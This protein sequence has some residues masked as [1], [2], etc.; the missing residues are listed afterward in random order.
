MEPSIRLPC[1]GGAVGLIGLLW[2]LYTCKGT[3]LPR[4]R[5]GLYFAPLMLVLLVLI[6][7]KCQKTSGWIAMTSKVA[8]LLFLALAA[9][10]ATQAQADFLYLWRYDAGTKRAYRHFADEA[11]NQHRSLRVGYEWIFGPGLVFYRVMSGR[12]IFSASQCTMP[13]S[14]E[15]FDDYYLGGDTAQQWEGAGKLQVTWRDPISGAKIG[16]PR[17]P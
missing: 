3:P 15:S 11:E 10:F 16:A 8:P 12:E 4:D 5:T 2:L 14:D 6:V 1:R 13:S 9:H 7:G 17:S